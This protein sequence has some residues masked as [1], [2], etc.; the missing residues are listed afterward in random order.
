MS[1]TVT[2]PLLTPYTSAA[3]R[4]PNRLVMAPMTRFRA[5]ED[6]TPLP[7]VAEYY[8][9]RAAA[10]LIVTEGIWPHRRGQ[11][12]WR[13][14]GLET[15]DHAEGW[16]AVTDAVHARSGRIFAQLM[17]G[18]R[19]GHPRSRLLGDLPAG[20]SAVAV[21]GPLHVKDGKVEA[22]TPRTMTT[23]DI[24]VAVDDHVNA[25]R[26]A[27]RAGFDGV[28]L[29]GANSYLIHQF[30]ADNTNLRSDGYGKDRARFAVELVEAVASAVGAHRL[31]LRLSPGNPQFGMVERDP[32][33]VYRPLV[34]ALNPLGLAYLH[35]T[36]NDNYPA[37]ADL[38]PRWTGTLIAN[39]GENHAPTTREQG[40]GVVTEGHADLVSY[41]R[42]FL[43]HPDLPARIAAD[44][45]L[46]TPIDTEHL[47]TNGAR[48]Y[49][50]YPTLER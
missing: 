12:G 16:R 20:P 43:A 34:E 6:G 45:P 38:R 29:H 25:A 4:L 28:E 42:A 18:G 3:L 40:E 22:P 33:P 36:D 49:T 26:N 50:D 47:Y 37:L 24:R 11:S 17:H 44:A 21:P 14:P 10:G 9:Q 23:D 35:L 48:G 32:G 41:G 30:L 2:S 39:V 13:M 15:E 5:K 46:T 7:V 8:A 1:H 31:G 19:Q 27:L